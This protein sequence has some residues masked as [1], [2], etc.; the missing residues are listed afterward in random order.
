MEY[1]ESSIPEEFIRGDVS[2]GNKRHLIFA[3]DKQL[4]IL[5]NTKTWYIDGT[6]KVIKH[7]F[8]QL[9]SI[10]GF[11]KSGDDMKQVPLCYCVM[12]GKKKKDYKKVSHHKYIII[13]S[14]LIRI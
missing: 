5:A 8:Y 13:P 4:D 11:I 2:V 9:L 6:F 7:P 14:I 10:H 1:I 3:T 12:S